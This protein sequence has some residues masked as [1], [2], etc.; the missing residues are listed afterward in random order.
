MAGGKSAS[1]VARWDG[2][3]WSPSVRGSAAPGGFH[4]APAVYALAVRGR[5][6]YAGGRFVTAGG[7]PA[8]GIARWDGRTWTALGGGVRT[9]MYDGVVR[10]LAARGGS[11]P[12]VS[13]SSAGGAEAY[14]IARWDG[15]QVGVWAAASG[16][17]WKT[18]W[19]SG[20]RGSD[21]YVGG[22]F[23][24]AGGV[25]APNIAKWNS[26]WSAVDVRPHD[27]NRTMWWPAAVSMPAAPPSACP[28]ERPARDRPVG[29]R[30]WSGLG[31]GVGTRWYAGPIM[32]ISPSGGKVYVGGDAFTFPDARDLAPKRAARNAR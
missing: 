28:T 20:S 11:M 15:Q 31:G 26:T 32:A 25:H 22:M 2:R 9:G 17:I 13:S 27:G 21:V 1:G 6:V 23:A 12:A 24:D 10:A 3:K 4:R 30:T 14:N 7:T 18:S 29:R 16:V 5:E 8:N 19:R